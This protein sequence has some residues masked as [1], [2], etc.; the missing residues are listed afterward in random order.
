M[1]NEYAAARRA[2][3]L[4]LAGELVAFDTPGQD[5]A[6]CDALADHL[7]A[8]MAPLGALTRIANPSGGDQLRLRVAAPQALAGAR[9]ALLLCHYDTV[10]PVGTAAARPLRLDGDTAYGPGLYDMKA[11]IAMVALALHAINELGLRL[12]R[13]LTL[14]LTSDEEIGSPA[15]RELIE[16]EARAAAHVLVLEPPIE[17][18]SLLKTARKGVG[19]FTLNISGRAAHAG[20]E[21]EKGVNAL[22]ELA[23]QIIA[24]GALADPTQGTT[25]S[26]GLAHGG[27]ACNV[28]PA[29]ASCDVDVRAWSAAEAARLEAGFLALQP[30]LPGA[31]LTVTGGFNRPPME[32][33]PASLA[34][35]A[36]A[37]ALGAGLGLS[38]GEGATGG[39]SDGNFT[40]ALGVPTL[41][42]LGAPGQ[43]AHAEH[44]QI[45]LTGTLERLALL[46]AL[47]SEL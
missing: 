17:Q 35:F 4:T 24:V 32:R 33:T 44:E 3:L 23:H 16:T 2:D 14:L 40:A 46:I 38:L 39:A 31:R 12:P 37:Q 20:V 29:A 47:L 11:S 9:P 22:T 7:A 36:R 45:S 28:V 15:S 43:G 34:L 26:V 10:W 8:L 1:L 25:V 21:P 6:R 41:D 5:K 19:M 18:G 30:V 27:S 13:P 42:G